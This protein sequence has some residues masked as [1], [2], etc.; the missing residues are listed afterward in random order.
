MLFGLLF[1]C[2][3]DIDL[4]IAHTPT[5][6]V[7]C[8]VDPSDSFCIVTLSKSFQS[9]SD[10]RKV[11]SNGED[12]LV[13]N[14][15]IV[16]EAWGAGYKAW[17][18]G[19]RLVEPIASASSSN[20]ISR[21]VYRSI[22]T[23]SFQ[24]PT[25]YNPPQ[26][27]MYDNLRLIITSP[28]FEKIIYSKIPIPDA[29]RLN[30]PLT[31]IRLNLFGAEHSYFLFLLKDKRIRYAD[32]VCNF[33]YQEFTDQWIDRKAQLI[34]KMNIPVRDSLYIRIF[35]E[36]FFNKLVQKIGHNPDVS[37]RLFNYMDFT[38]LTSDV[39]FHDYYTT[40]EGLDDNDFGAYTNIING[41]GLFS[42]RKKTTVPHLI[43]DRMTLDSL[44][45]GRL[46]KHLHFRDW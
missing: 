5:P 20:V 43:F 17:E 45:H 44:Y 7:Y 23:L 28:E 40:Y 11:F 21:S 34:L 25:S 19:F 2:S 16:L 29:P 12:L 27:G 18:T 46:T 10:A 41:L 36:S 15:E 32:F 3:N 1:S 9:K 26:P 14:A 30:H 33:C 24:D 35:E 38:L 8:Q 22:K 42:V 31:P 39:Y 4:Y 6:L 37:S 13:D